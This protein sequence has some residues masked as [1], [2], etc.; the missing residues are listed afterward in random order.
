MKLKN[1]DQ[2]NDG[3]ITREEWQGDSNNSFIN[4]D[5]NGDGI[6]SDNEVK[7]GASRPKNT[8]TLLNQFSELD[9]NND[10]MI[11]QEEWHNTTRSFE[12]LDLN[13]NGKLS[14]DEFYNRQQ[15]PISVFSELDQNNDRMISRIEWRSTN[16]AFNNLDTNGNNLL[17]ENE[18][19]VR[20]SSSLVERIFHEIFRKQ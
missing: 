13:R 3:I 14:R 2:N 9:H 7:P 8:G 5:W 15:Y 10:G 1:M 19:N 11:V 20:Q 18:F 17:S 6:L 16:N 4:H 12:G